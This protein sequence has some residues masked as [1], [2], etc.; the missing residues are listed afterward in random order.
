MGPGSEGRMSEGAPDATGAG[1]MEARGAV[2]MLANEHTFTRGR[3][4]REAARGPV[5]GGVR[6]RG[7]PA[8]GE[9]AREGRGVQVTACRV[10]MP[11][12]SPARVTNVSFESSAELD[13]RRPPTQTRA[14]TPG[15]SAPGPRPAHDPSR[16]GGGVRTHSDFLCLA[17]RP[18]RKSARLARPPRCG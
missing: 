12:H 15:L 10:S 3:S 11:I 6:R 4:E 2:D 1:V 5:T 17:T 18:R 13:F 14:R 9:S 7:R 8:G 16:L